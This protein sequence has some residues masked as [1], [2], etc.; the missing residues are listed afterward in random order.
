MDLREGAVDADV[1]LSALKDAAPDIVKVVPEMA[2]FLPFI[3]FA[4]HVIHTVEQMNGQGTGNAVS[5]VA[6]TLMQH[7]PED[8]P[9]TTAHVDAAG[10][11][12]ASGIAVDA[13]AALQAVP[14]PG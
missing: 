7:L 3:G 1:A 2:G 12:V 4:L 8:S 11:A 9:V 6:S 13:I 10:A 5:T 14:A